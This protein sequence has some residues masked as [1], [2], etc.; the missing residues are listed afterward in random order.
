MYCLKDNNKMMSLYPSTSLRFR[1]HQH[2][3]R[4]WLHAPL[5]PEKTSILHFVN[6]PLFFFIVLP[7]IY[8]FLQYIIQSSLSI[9]RVFVP[10]PAKVTK[11]CGG[12]S[13]IV[14]LP[15]SGI[16][17]P[18]IQPTINIVVCFEKHPRVSGLTQF[19]PMVFKGQL[20]YKVGPPY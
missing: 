7:H 20:C 9:G 11:I 5:P 4:C 19:K 8:V 12:S 3:W 10:G 6:D 18:G 1:N 2:L 15:Y 17:H 13:P 14:C 16:L